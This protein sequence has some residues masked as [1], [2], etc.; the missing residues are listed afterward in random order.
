MPKYSV[1]D[2]VV[3]SVNGACKIVDIGTLSFGG[4][5]K[6]Y[7]SMK[8]V[9]DERS[10]IYLPVTREDE[11]NR[12]VMEAGEVDNIIDKIKKCKPLKNSVDRESGE[13]IIKSGDSVEIAKMIKKLR[14]LR[15]EN[16]K[17]HKGLNIQE[18]KM[19]REAE[20]VLYS[21]F[22]IAYNLTMD[23]IVEKYSEIFD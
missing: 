21:E 20:I 2:Y 13:K 10:T 15:I 14:I 3:Y 5:D 9:S 16:R 6:I 17:I 23:E 12:L 4:P 22:S 1:D 8:P 18:E 19:L 11:I 7:Y